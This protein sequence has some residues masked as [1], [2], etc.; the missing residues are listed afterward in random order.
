MLFNLLT[1]C[2]WTR[3]GV[4]DTGEK[5]WVLKLFW[6]CRIRVKAQRY[7]LKPYMSLW[8]YHIISLFLLWLI[9]YSF[10]VNIHSPQHIMRNKSAAADVIHDDDNDDVDK[11]KTSHRTLTA[12][13]LYTWDE[14]WVS[15]RSGCPSSRWRWYSCSMPVYLSRRRKDLLSVVVRNMMPGRGAPWLSMKLPNSSLNSQDS[16]VNTFLVDRYYIQLITFT[17][18]RIHYC[19]RQLHIWTWSSTLWTG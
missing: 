15:P 7:F 10:L 19:H 4:S 16:S 11:V 6:G 17:T 18:Y 14:R 9:M 8:T 5:K 3:P 1:L 12:N 2:G 13:S